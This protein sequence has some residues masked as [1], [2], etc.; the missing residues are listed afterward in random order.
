MS[1]IYSFAKRNE[2]EEIHIFQGQ[3]KP[4]PAKD[5]TANQ[6]SI[7]RKASRSNTAWVAS[8]GCLSEQVAR[9]KAAELGR[10]VCG[11]CVSHLYETY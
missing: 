9:Q 1:T 11:T 2:T 6:N 7:C 3:T 5:C 8:A 10:K 4:A